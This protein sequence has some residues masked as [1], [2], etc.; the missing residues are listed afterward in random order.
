[1]RRW[2]A[3]VLFALIVTCVAGSQAQSGSAPESPARWDG[4][5]RRMR[6]P[7]LMYH[8]VSEVPV[9]ADE[10][11]I[12]LTV[13]P[14]AFEQQMDYLFSEGYSTIDLSQLVDA[15]LTGALLPPKPVV[16][17]FDDGYS[18]HYTTVF[19]TMRARGQTGTFF[20]ITGTAD[21][22][23][24][25]YLNWPQ[26]VEMAAA[27]MALENHTRDHPDLRGRDYAFLVYQL[28]GAKESL[29]AYTQRPVDFF[30]YPVGRYDD[31]VLEILQTLPARAA[32]TT[33]FGTLQTTDSLLELPRVRISNDTTPGAFASLL[34]M[35][36]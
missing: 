4:T 33:A 5:L 31:F 30:A 1:M 25:G 22:N 12:N 26:I 17:T 28:L 20:V 7:I 23:V 19:P 18:D 24:T 14:A 2:L 8:Y 29:I 10:T 3:F 15:L 32:V 9:D 13:T 11:R 36:A 34:N 27:G 16:L 21:Q 6:V 35:D